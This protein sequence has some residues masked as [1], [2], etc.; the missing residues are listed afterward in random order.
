MT[1][2]ELITKIDSDLLDLEVRKEQLIALKKK[3]QEDPNTG[4]EDSGHISFTINSE[5]S[6]ES[7]PETKGE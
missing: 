2:D 7:F 3:I 1:I 6:F 5:T 4:K